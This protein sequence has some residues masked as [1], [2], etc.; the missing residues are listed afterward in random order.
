M[1]QKALG[2]AGMTEDYELVIIGAGAAGLTA[3]IYGVRYGL[4]TVVMEMGAPGGQTAIAPWVENFPGIKHI[5]GMELI[6]GIIEHAEE[7]VEIKTGQYV[8]EIE[9]HEDFIILKTDNVEYKT[10]A[11]I[12]AT[13]AAHRR[14]GVPGESEFGGRGVSFC[15]TCDGFFFKGKKVAV[16]GGGDSALV[17]AIYLASL[18]C[19][20]Y[21]IHRRDEL[22]ASKRLQEQYAEAGGE[23]VWDSVVEEIKGNKVVQELALLNKKTGEKSTLPVDGVFISI[24]IVPNSRL[25]KEFGVEL[26]GNGYISVDR[27]MR[28]NIPMVYA[29]GDV[30]GGVKQT[31]VACGEGAVAALSAYEDVR[32]PP[33]LSK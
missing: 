24:G 22:R 14:L 13:G 33:H 25:A 32:R 15:A 2:G 6:Q 4:K 11:I 9:R 17:E 30:S 26:D 12:F 31:I 21:V 18:D 19:E 10:R 7:Y 23:V 16:V 28:T 5:S 3:G 20:M 8:K 29:A 27:S 1:H